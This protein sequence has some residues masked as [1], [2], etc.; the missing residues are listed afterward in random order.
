ML[1]TYADIMLRVAIDLGIAR[2]PTGTSNTPLLPSDPS[3]L[4]R[5]RDGVERGIAEFYADFPNAEFRRRS[6]EVAISNSEL[7]YQVGGDKST[8]ALPFDWMG[9]PQ[10]SIV[11]SGG[12]GGE[13]ILTSMD[14]VRL[15]HAQ[16]Q[17]SPTGIP[18][19]I[20][21]EREASMSY[22]S[23]TRWILRVWPTPDQ[24][25]TL[26]LR[27]R[28]RAV[29]FDDYD[30]EPT[31]N[32]EAIAAYATIYLIEKGLISTGVGA[33][34]A[35]QKKQEWRERIARE[36]A[37]NGPRTL[38]RMKTARNTEISPPAIRATNPWAV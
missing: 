38:G 18:Q 32:Q 11:I 33:D 30:V 5:L 6:I 7:P 15:A 8:Y 20:A 27:G 4:F 25:Y 31:G 2:Y 10:G 9:P 12:I 14:R 16:D 37:Q 23:E 24:D 36:E 13:A 19:L 3:T 28:W 1:S 35:R 34:S 21:C 22:G 26:T 17:S 29:P